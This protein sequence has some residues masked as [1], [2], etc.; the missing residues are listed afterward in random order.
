MWRH[1]ALGCEDDGARCCV[2]PGDGRLA[3]RIVLT[4]GPKLVA[5]DAT[6][7]PSNDFGDKG[8]VEIAVPWNGVPT[9]YKNVAI[10]GATTG[11]VNLAEPAIRAHSMCAP[12]N[13]CGTFTR[14]R[15]PASSVTT[16]GSTTDGGTARA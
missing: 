8:V 5:L 11:E 15:C 9:I 6:G 7:T 14:C 1:A 4:A 2:W 13:D 16:P 3:A 10:L 12:A